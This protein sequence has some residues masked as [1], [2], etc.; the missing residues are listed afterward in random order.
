MK[1]IGFLSQI[2]LGN[3]IRWRKVLNRTDINTGQKIQLKLLRRA[4]GLIGLEGRSKHCRLCFLFIKI[5][6]E[7]PLKIIR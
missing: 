5:C 4:V 7:S 2:K 6:Y 3:G 1:S